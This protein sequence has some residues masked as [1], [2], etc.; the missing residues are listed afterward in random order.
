M[1]RAAGSEHAK[2]AGGSALASFNFFQTDI[3]AK[4]TVALAD[5]L[6]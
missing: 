2:G 3:G 5:L 4:G 1:V 6:R